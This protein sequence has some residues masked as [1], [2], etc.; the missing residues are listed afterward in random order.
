MILLMN[1]VQDGIA[2][3]LIEALNPDRHGSVGKYSFEPSHRMRSDLLEVKIQGLPFREPRITYKRM[4]GF[5]VASRSGGIIGI[6]VLVSRAVYPTEL[7]I[8]K[9]STGSFRT[10]FKP[11]R[12]ARNAG[13]NLS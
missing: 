10:D 8:S 12:M 6:L 13:E 1:V 2:L 5:N 9:S 4:D 3:G 11:S 7:E